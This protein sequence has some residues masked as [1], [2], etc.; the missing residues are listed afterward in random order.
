MT[1][2]CLEYINDLF[3]KLKIPYE[4]MEWSTN[5]PETFWIGEYQEI[6]SL[7]EDG[8]EEGTFILTGTTT[9]SFLELERVKEKV[10]NT[11]SNC[12]FTDIMKSGSGISITYSN[13]FPIPSVEFGV[14]RLQIT[15]NIKEWRVN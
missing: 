12:G 9:K 7:N 8:M 1:T 15:L 4:F 2:E 3:N 10:K 5:I 13:A 6:T 11:I 14:H